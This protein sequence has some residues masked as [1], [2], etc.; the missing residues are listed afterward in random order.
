MTVIGQA[1]YSKRAR[2]SDDPD[3]TRRMR[4]NIAD[5]FLSN[6]ISANRAWEMF[7]DGIASG[8]RHMK[9][10]QKA[11]KKGQLPKNLN[12]DLTKKMM[13]KNNWPPVY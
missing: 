5:L 8:T 13:K 6:D 9:D 3:P 2:V 12:R 1:M 10:L 4:N 7:D 11:G